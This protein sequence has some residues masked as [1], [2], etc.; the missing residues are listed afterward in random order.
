[1]ERKLTK[2]RNRRGPAEA[3]KEAERYLQA[4]PTA[5]AKD[6]AATFKIDVSTVYR[7]TW[8]KN[9]AHKGQA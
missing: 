2:T 3:T 4:N 8:W 5:K 7:A 6:V 1:M 9:R